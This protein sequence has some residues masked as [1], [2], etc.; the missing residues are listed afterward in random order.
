MAP[1]VAINGRISVTTGFPVVM[2]PVLSRT[3]IFARPAASKEEAVLYK[4]PFCA[5]FPFP[6][7]MATG[8]ARP[9]AQG[10]E[11]TKT[12]M[13]RSK[14]KAT[15][16]PVRSQI[17]AVIRASTKTVGTKTPATLSAIF[18]MGAFVAAASET[19]WIIFEM[20]V[21]E[22]TRVTRHFKNPD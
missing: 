2:V 15:S 22:P 19:I 3:T 12:A 13:A 18:A 11:I 1:S 14:E 9:K 10:Q 5:P 6:T 16:A 20:V 8:V 21:S 7:I 17:I 4:I